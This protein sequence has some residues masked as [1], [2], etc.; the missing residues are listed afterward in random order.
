M[1]QRFDASRSLTTLEQ[2]STII[3]A[4]GAPLRAAGIDRQRGQA[5]ESRWISG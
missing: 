3:A 4:I 5:E 2:D 1:S